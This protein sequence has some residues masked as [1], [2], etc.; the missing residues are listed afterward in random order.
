MWPRVCPANCW[1]VACIL[2]SGPVSG[3]YCGVAGDGGGRILARLLQQV[4]DGEF[5]D[6]VLWGG[7]RSHREVQ[8]ILTRPW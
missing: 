8:S 3:P 1:T 2:R 7:S 5:I 6:E 4:F